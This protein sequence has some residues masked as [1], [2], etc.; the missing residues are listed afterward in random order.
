MAT[1]I[2]EYDGGISIVGGFKP[3]GSK[4]LMEAK[5]ILVGNNDKR[6]DEVLGSGEGSIQSQITDAL[7]PY[8][9]TAQ[10]KSFND[11]TNYYKRSIKG[12][13]RHWS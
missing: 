6:L 4:P 9:T 5:D 10:V 3:A 1:H 8:S 12:C 13:K 7:N 11:M 2:T